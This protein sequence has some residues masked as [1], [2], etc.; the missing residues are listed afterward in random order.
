[1]AAGPFLLFPRGAEQLLAQLRLGTKK[2]V[3]SVSSREQP[4]A[5][6]ARSLSGRAGAPASRPCAERMPLTRLHKDSLRP[7][8]PS[9][10]RRKLSARLRLAGQESQARPRLLP[11]WPFSLA[12]EPPARAPIWLCLPSVSVSALGSGADLPPVPLCRSSGLG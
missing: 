12:P 2:R 9:G 10:R 5:Q 1:M 6:R 4:C 11:T 8:V 3:P 7:S